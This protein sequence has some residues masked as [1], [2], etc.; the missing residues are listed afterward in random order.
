MLLEKTLIFV[1]EEHLTSSFILGM[2]QLISP[3]KWCFSLIPV[4]PVALVDMLDAPVPL[5]VGITPSEYNVL[6]EEGILEN[7]ME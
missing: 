1:G 3:L 2:N 5:I 6:F 7:E 4:L